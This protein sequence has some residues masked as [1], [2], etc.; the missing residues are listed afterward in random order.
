ML[1]GI[2]LVFGE[3]V[4][5]KIVYS[6]VVLADVAD[7]MSGFFL[8][9]ACFMLYFSLCTSKKLIKI[10]CWINVGFYIKMKT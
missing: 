4:F 8:L 1:I 6:L 5:Q 2:I 10:T 3:F 7:T 9:T